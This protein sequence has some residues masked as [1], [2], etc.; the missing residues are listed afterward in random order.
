MAGGLA[1]VLFGDAEPAGRLPTTFP[2]LLEHNPSYGNFPG[3]N[4]TLRYGEGLLI[5]YRWYETRRLPV[6][7]AFGHGLSYTRFE[8]GAPLLE[9]G[10]LARGEPLRVG[11]SVTNTGSRRGAEVV[12]CY[13]AP[14]AGRL[15]RPDRE[16]RAF[17]KV[18]LDPGESARVTLELGLRAFA[19][20]DPGDP[21]HA[22]ILE[23][24]GAAAN[25]VPAGGREKRRSEAG[26]YVD[27][28]VYALH[29]GRSSAETAHVLRVEV[30]AE[31]GPLGP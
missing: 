1:D 21:G 7:F 25:L 19:Y 9:G 10:D 11:V 16:L 15:F 27:P 3:E 2:S 4:S 12:Q 31:L 18:W 8:L 22:A 6:R 24:L 26:W 30:A 13:V 5:G 20:W 28:G 14:P 29:V 23:H 17:E